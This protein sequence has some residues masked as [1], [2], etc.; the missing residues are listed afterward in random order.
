MNIKQLVEGTDTWAGKAFDLVIQALIFVSLI[1]FSIETLPDLGNE[2]RFWLYV[3]EVVTVAI[4]TIEYGLRILVADNRLRFIFSF[5]GLVDLTA[6]LPFYISTG[7]DLRAVRVLRLFRV[8]RVFK[9]LRYTQA[10]QR[11]KDAFN[12]IREELVLYLVATSLMIFLSSVGIYYFENE[13]Q[14]ENFG[15]VFHCLWW[16]IV[17]LTTVGYGDVFPITVGGRIF[18]AIVLL[19]GIGTIAVPAGLLAAA[20]TKTQKKKN[21][22]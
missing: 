16:A 6:I 19:F 12:E 8:F 1:S 5:Y 14:P 3:V 20:L 11:F 15:S 18:T 22:G 21:G 9:L 10:I 7:V 2:S 4:F 13:A 17:T